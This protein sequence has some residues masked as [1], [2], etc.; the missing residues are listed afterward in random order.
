M[1]QELWSRL[2]LDIV[3]NH[4]FP[5]LTIEQRLGLGVPPNRFSQAYLLK[6]NK[7]LKCIMRTKPQVHYFSTFADGS[8][9]SIETSRRVGGNVYIYRKHVLSRNRRI[10]IE[11]IDYNEKV[12]DFWFK[13]PCH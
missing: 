12:H 3:Y 8:L 13:E 5:K 11:E 9:R 6:I 1:N 2:P 10:C 7:R 4:V